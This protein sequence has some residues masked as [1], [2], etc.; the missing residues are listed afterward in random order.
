MY[1]VFVVLWLVASP[2][3]PPYST[4][5]M[6]G[7]IAILGSTLSP[8]ELRK[9]ALSCSSRYFN[10]FPSHFLHSL[11]PLLYIIFGCFYVF[12]FSSHII[13]DSL[14]IVML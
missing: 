1:R 6:C 12:F 14:N 11:T 3:L 9:L 4:L 2:L 8:Q 10:V 5:I 7:I 13:I